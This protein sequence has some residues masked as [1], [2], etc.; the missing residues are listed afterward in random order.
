MKYP[1]SNSLYKPNS[2]ASCKKISFE[3]VGSS[4]T[5]R[6]DVRV[7]AT[8]NRNLI[9]ASAQGRFREDLYY[10]LAVVPLQ[11]PALRER[12]DDLPELTG[13]FLRVQHND[14][15]AKSAHSV[16]AP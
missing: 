16:T 2:C 8:S 11:L 13:H 7:L 5:I 1:R 6:V 4:K 3:R 9:E 10:R 12:R 14:Y 15:N